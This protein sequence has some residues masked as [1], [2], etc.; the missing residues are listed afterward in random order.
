MSTASSPNL[1]TE[2]VYVPLLLCI[3]MCLSFEVISLWLD[4]IIVAIAFRFMIGGFVRATYYFKAHC[5]EKYVS[6]LFHLLKIIVIQDTIIMLVTQGLFSLYSLLM[7]YVPTLFIFIV[8]HRK[9]Q[10]MEWWRTRQQQQ[11]SV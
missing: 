3:Q 1:I 2:S 5:D 11:T 9:A 6:E 10:L 8:I 4:E 7:V